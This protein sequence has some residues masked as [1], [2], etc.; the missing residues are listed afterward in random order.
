VLISPLT[1]NTVFLIDSGTAARVVNHSP[2]AQDF[3]TAVA[4][5]LPARCF[6]STSWKASNISSV[7]LSCSAARAPSSASSS[8]FTSVSML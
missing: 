5:A 1:L 8:A 3:I 2:S 6:S 4:C 7:P